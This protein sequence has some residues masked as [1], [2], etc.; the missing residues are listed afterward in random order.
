MLIPTHKLLA[1][2]RRHNYA[3]GAFNVYNLEGA[4]AVTQAAR[5]L[6]SPVILQVLPSALSIGGTTLVKLCL[7]AAAATAVP[8]AVHLDHCASQDFIHLALQAGVS[9]VMADGSMHDYD[10]NIEFTRRMVQL[11]KKYSAD[12]EAELG[13]IQGEEDGLDFGSL[14]EKMT[15]PARAVDFVEK[16]KPDALAVCIGNIH[17]RYTTPP[18]LDFDRLAAIEK[19]VSVP[20]VLHGTSGL[21]EEMILQAIR[22]GICKFNVNTEIR[23]AF[24]DLLGD[25]F[26]NN[27]RPE[28]I[29]IMKQGIDAMKEPVKE[30]IRLFGA[31]NKAVYHQN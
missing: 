3:V 30:K 13:S 21:P 27:G 7:E 24:I 11:A 26:Q 9:S 2:A 5:E 28:L 4:L 18:R 19:C 22:L 14:P 31:V 29:A 16:T 20:L 12:V 25:L 23:M 8:V 15:D 10:T 1:H 17:G 6:N